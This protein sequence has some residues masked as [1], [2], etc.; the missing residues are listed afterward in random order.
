MVVR[1]PRREAQWRGQHCGGG[2]GPTSSSISGYGVQSPPHQPHHDPAIERGPRRASRPFDVH[3][4]A[5]TISHGRHHR[6]GVQTHRVM[7][8]PQ[9]PLLRCRR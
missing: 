9:P 8:R 6:E 7:S 2:N 3:V 5:G 4:V 1:R